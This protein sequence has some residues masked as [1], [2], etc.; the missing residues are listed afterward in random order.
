ML[1]AVR[2]TFIAATAAAAIAL[3]PAAPAHAWGDKEQGFV[4]GV[5]TFLILNEIAKDA[6]KRRAPAYQ[7]P[8][9]IYVPA[10]PPPVYQSSPA[11]QAFLEYSP[12]A[13][14]A[15]QQRLRSYG[16]YAGSIDGVW[17]PGTARAVEAYARDVGYG[18]GL[19]TRNG[20]V[21][22]YNALLA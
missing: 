11:K 20:A 4:A 3:T 2:N 15:I 18:G 9:P 13:R 16:Y 22:L 21:Q 7:A 12:N 8:Q 17:G 14:R 19:G 1:P 5:A 10:N 6:K